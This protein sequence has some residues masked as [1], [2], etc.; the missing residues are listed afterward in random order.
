MSIYGRETFSL[1]RLWTALHK[2][3]RVTLLEAEGPLAGPKRRYRQE[4]GTLMTDYPFDFAQ[5]TV[6]VERPMGQQV[7]VPYMELEEWTSTGNP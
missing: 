2:G 4:D 3:E 6:L 1:D 5:T 7:R